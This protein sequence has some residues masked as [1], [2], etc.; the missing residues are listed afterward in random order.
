VK[1]ALVWILILCFALPAAADTPQPP[2]TQHEGPPACALP[3]WLCLSPQLGA[4][5]PA[6]LR[7]C[8]AD[9]D[10]RERHAIEAGERS[11]MFER[12]RC[13]V[14]VA[15]ESRA[16][17]AALRKVRELEAEDKEGHSNGAVIG[18]TAGG[19]TFGVGLGALLYWLATRK[20]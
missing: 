16:T 14:E 8:K 2:C 3:D 1:R 17:T 9:A 6:K 18:W 10:A 15:A 13:A 4:V 20:P 11:V 12:E 7:R 19:I 5:C